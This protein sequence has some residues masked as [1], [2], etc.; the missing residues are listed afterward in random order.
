MSVSRAQHHNAVSHLR[1]AR[2]RLLQDLGFGA[3][4]RP[5]LWRFV[6]TIGLITKVDNLLF[7]IWRD[8]SRAHDGLNSP[9]SVI[10]YV[11]LFGELILRNF[12]VQACDYGRQDLDPRF[13]GSRCALDRR[14]AK[15]IRS[16]Q[17]QH[18][19]MFLY[20]GLRPQELSIERNFNRTLTMPL[21]LPSHSQ[22]TKS[23]PYVA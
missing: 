11:S 3:R 2:H 15:A 8:C 18:Q 14:G 10:L 23:L 22:M 4:T 13:D 12:S 9:Q 19:S 6:G 17:C 20:F 7:S 1:S 21:E 16:H 5:A